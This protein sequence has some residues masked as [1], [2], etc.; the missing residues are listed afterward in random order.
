MLR[1]CFVLTG[2]SVLMAVNVAGQEKKADRQVADQPLQS[3]LTRP[4]LTGQYSP[5]AQP[6]G[7][8]SA[9]NSY[10]PVTGQPFRAEVN[11]RRI[12]TKPDGTKIIYEYHGIAARD[13]QGRVFREQIASPQI[14]DVDG[15][16]AAFNAHGVSVVDPLTKIEMKWSDLNKIAYESTPRQF[17]MTRQ[18]LDRCEMEQ[19]GVAAARNYPN[20]KNQRS[21]SLGERVIQGILTRGCRVYTV[22]PAGGNKSSLTITDESW[23]SPELRITLLRTRR[24]PTAEDEIIRLDNI[25]RSEPDAALFQPPSD[26]RILD[27]KGEDLPTA[28][29]NAEKSLHPSE[30]T[31]PISVEHKNDSLLMKID[32]PRPL[33]VAVDFLR[34]KY[35]WKIDY[36]EPPFIS[37]LIDAGDPQWRA[38]H[39]PAPKSGTLIPAGGKFESEYA[40]VSA[41]P[42]AVDGEKQIMEKIVADY[43]QSDNPGKFAVRQESAN[44]FAVVG[45]SVRDKF[46]KDKIVTPILDTPITIAAEQR[47]GW[48]TVALILDEFYKK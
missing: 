29:Y 20:D 48:D 4:P 21:E 5:G 3:E 7:E 16:G 1:K 14:P 15:S 19:T 12:E 42:T 47:S 17:Y 30:F 10:S 35:G 6:F 31:S 26:Y 23:T 8:A 28:A 40:E 33:Q 43:N 39:Q 27:P 32:N 37:E 2:V 46:G 38:N 13:S 45:V 22:I 9:F 44:R 18:P 36:E 41:Q 25:V 24:D 11:A 34:L